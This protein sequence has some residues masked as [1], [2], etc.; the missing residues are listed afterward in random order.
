MF[1][2]CPIF[3]LTLYL[4]ATGLQTIQFLFQ[5]EIIFFHAAASSM[6]KSNSSVKKR[7]SSVKKSKKYFFSR[8]VYLFHAA[9][10]VKVSR[11]WICTTCFT[12]EGS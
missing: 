1:K 12:G 10:K 4:I 11:I 6:K 7:S 2:L 8:W 3:S 5:A 9:E